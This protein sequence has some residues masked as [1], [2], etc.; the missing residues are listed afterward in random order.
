LVSEKKYKKNFW[1]N[2]TKK[3]FLFSQK[4]LKKKHV[5]VLLWKQSWKQQTELS[6]KELTLLSKNKTTIKFN[7]YLKTKMKWKKSYV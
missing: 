2:S 4:F 1:T 5:F 6:K 7:N 3:K